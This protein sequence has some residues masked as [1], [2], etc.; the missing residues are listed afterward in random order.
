MIGNG[1]KWLDINGNIFNILEI[2]EHVKMDDAAALASEI[3]GKCDFGIPLQNWH[4]L[5]SKHQLGAT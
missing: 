1:F 4:T 2:P 3:P 5:L